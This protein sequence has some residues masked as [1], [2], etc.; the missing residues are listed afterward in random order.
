M[1]FKA[2]ATME[3]FIMDSNSIMLLI[4]GILAIIGGF[5]ELIYRKEI[6]EFSARVFKNKYFLGIGDYC[7]GPNSEKV[8]GLAG[9]LIII[10]GLIFIIEVF[11]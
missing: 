2:S 3:D 8:L 7:G 10:T 6:N 4:I 11:Q 5:W 1:F 9:I